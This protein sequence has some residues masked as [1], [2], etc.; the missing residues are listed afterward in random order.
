M[1]NGPYCCPSFIKYVLLFFVPYKDYDEQHSHGQHHS[2]R[3]S[4]KACKEIS[5]KCGNILIVRIILFCYD[6]EKREKTGTDQ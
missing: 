2:Q 1:C 4:G 6:Y 3:A 5:G